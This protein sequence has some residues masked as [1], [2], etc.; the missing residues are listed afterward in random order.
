MPRHNDRAEPIEKTAK[1]KHDA[2]KPTPVGMRSGGATGSLFGTDASSRHAADNLPDI[3][4][5]RQA[6]PILPHDDRP[7]LPGKDSAGGADQLE[8][9]TSLANKGPA[10]LA[11]KGT[12]GQASAYS[13]Q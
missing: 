9:G 8:S 6:A 1:E 4:A 5:D 7:P 13:Q 10:D 12:A 11:D 2:A 3:A